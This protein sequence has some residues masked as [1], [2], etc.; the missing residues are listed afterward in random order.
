M[1]DYLVIHNNEQIGR[2]VKPEADDGM[3]IL[4]GR[5]VPFQAYEGVRQ[6]CQMYSYTIIDKQ[7]Q[8]ERRPN[9]MGAVTAFYCTY[10]VGV[11]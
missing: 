7:L 6:I 8:T 3:G 5:F 10:V 4:I 9:F 11:V 1:M 2:A